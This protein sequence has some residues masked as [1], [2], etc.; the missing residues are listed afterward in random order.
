MSQSL[1]SVVV[2]IAV[3]AMVP[4]GLRWL[5]QRTGGLPGAVPGS[6]S[7]VVSALGVGPTQR[8]VTVEV[9]PPEARVWLVLGVTAQNVTPLHTMPA[10][11][12]A[13][14]ARLVEASASPAAHDY[15]GPG[16]V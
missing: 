9:G 6:G 14:A 2:F 1:L 3:L 10:P 11:G 8:V 16:H 15:R 4:W 12:F 13:Q 7:R 5:K